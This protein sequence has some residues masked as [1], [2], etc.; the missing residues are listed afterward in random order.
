MNEDELRSLWQSDDAGMP[1]AFTVVELEQSPPVIAATPWVE[2]RTFLRS[3]L[4]ERRTALAARLWWLLLLLPLAGLLRATVEHMRWAVPVIVVIAVAVLALVARQ[5]LRII[6]TGRVLT[7]LRV[8]IAQTERP[9]RPLQRL[10]FLL[11][12]LCTVSGVGYWTWGQSRAKQVR[13]ERQQKGDVA[14]CGTDPSP[15]A[16]LAIAACERVLQVQ[17]DHVEAVAALKRLQARHACEERLRVAK[18]LAQQ[19]NAE[20]ALGAF[21]N[22]GAECSVTQ[23]EAATENAKPL[24]AGVSSAARADCLAAIEGEDWT[25]AVARCGVY[26]RYACQRMSLEELVPPRGKT[27]VSAGPLS[28]NGWR[29]ADQA[30]LGLLLARERL[31]EVGAWECPESAVLRATKIETGVVDASDFLRTEESADDFLR[32]AQTAFDQHRLLDALDW[33]RKAVVADPDNADAWLGLGFVN[34][35]LNKKKDAITA[36]K[37]Y[38]ELRPEAPDRMEVND[39]IYFLE[40]K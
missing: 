10:A 15:D 20:E 16:V 25:S 5:V 40:G 18:G 30:Y 27:F 26:A 17:P 36:F 24:V 2:N 23:I 12:V 13:E 22:L 1:L 33:Y 34:H 32:T 28:A 11:A 9:K 19:G 29:P 8:T 3:L 39:Q 35:E 7:E 6:A 4:T 14:E 31:G 37:R 38:L 21:S